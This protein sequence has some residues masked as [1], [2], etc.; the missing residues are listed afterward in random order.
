MWLN[1]KHTRRVNKW[2]GDGWVN[3]G[4]KNA[5]MF[6]RRSEIEGYVTEKFWRLF[7]LWHRFHVGMGFPFAGGWAEQPVVVAEAVE[8]M[9][10]MWRNWEASRGGK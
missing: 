5:P 9:E 1:G 8:V 10:T 3:A 4:T 7:E 6:V 2:V